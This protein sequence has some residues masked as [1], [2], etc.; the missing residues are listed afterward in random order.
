MYNLCTISTQSHLFKVFAL[1]DSL[2]VFN[3]VL[4]VLVV[5]G[6]KQISSN[7]I[8]VFHYL[9]E[10]TD[11]LTKALIKKYQSNLDRLRWALKPVFLK[12]LLTDK[13]SVIYVDNDVYFYGDSAFLFEKLNHNNILLTPHFYEA[14]PIQNQNWLEANFRVGLYNAGFIG[15][16][17]SAID[18][19]NW[20]ANCCLYNIKKS[21]WRGLFDDQKY[22][23]LVPI[24]FNKVEILKHNGC[25]LAGWNYKNYQIQ[26]S[27]EQSW[28][29]NEC[30]LVFIHFAELSLIE[31]SNPEN[32]LHKPYLVYLQA[33]KN[34]SP[35]YQFKRNIF[36][37]FTVMSYFYYLKWKAFRLIEN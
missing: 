20:W 33:L 9:N 30:S 12:H 21:Y 28:F 29:V 23:D 2:K 14:N 13:K 19:L 5:D 11:D 34:Y 24:L 16:N 22:L 31:F 7:Q 26:N 18:F 3:V 8:I 4:H 32:V 17:N 10:L 6:E 37:S 35:K 27:Q 15:V 1:A 36:K 25:N